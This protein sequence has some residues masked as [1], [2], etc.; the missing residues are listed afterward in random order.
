MS[1]QFACDHFTHI[2]IDEASQATEPE[3]L[4][5]IAGLI[6]PNSSTDC[7]KQVVL[8]GD[9]QQL[10]PILRSPY[11]KKFKLGKLLFCYLF[12]W[13]VASNFLCNKRHYNDVLLIA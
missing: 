11:A 7:G 2:F 3:S 10:G 6:Y 13:F 1:A 5:A 8:A 12:V 4:V 9:P